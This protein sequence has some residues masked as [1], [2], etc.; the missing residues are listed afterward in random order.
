M[1]LSQFPG[2]KNRQNAGRA[3]D[4]ALGTKSMF[5]YV[6]FVLKKNEIF[7]N[8]QISRR[9]RRCPYV[10]TSQGPEHRSRMPASA[11]GDGRGRCRGD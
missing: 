11:G 9:R 1:D 7:K 10:P 8:F 4:K 5:C 6:K 2:R 3:Q